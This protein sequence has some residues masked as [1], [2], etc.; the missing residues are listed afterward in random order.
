MKTISLSGFRCYDK[1]DIQF[2]SGFNLIVGDNASGKTSL[3]RAAR[4]ALSSFFSGFSDENTLWQSPDNADFRRVEVSDYTITEKPIQIDFSF[5]PELFQDSEYL[6]GE[7]LY[8]RKNSPKSRNILEGIKP[9]RDL[10]RGLMSN[11]YTIGEEGKIY[12]R[13]APLPLFDSISTIYTHTARPV[14]GN[15]FLSLKPKCTLGYNN[16]LTGG[17][18]GV[19]WW[20]RIKML[21]ETH[22]RVW[23]LEG[24]KESVVNALGPEGCDIISEVIPVVSL[25]EIFVVYKSGERVTYD[26]LPDGYL[27]LLDIVINIAFRALLLN[28]E[29]YGKDA[30]RQTHGVVLIDEIDMHLH[31]SL[32]STVIKALKHAFPKIQFIATTHSPIVMSGVENNDSDQVLFLKHNDDGIV[33]HTLPTFGRDVNSILQLLNL[34]TRNAETECELL[35]LFDLIEAGSNREARRILGRMREKY[36]DSLPDLIEAETMISINELDDEEDN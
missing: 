12:T 32:Q 9:L 15:R 35:N 16:A 18:Y 2:A 6:L 1:I 17:G 29:I 36:G 24:V 4:F 19:Q 30:P 31:P 27:R 8:I 11:L 20:Q 14:K 25:N 22:Q 34:R 10:G 28:G 3:L 23:E 7:K 13:T 33:A 5:Y 21:A 26:I